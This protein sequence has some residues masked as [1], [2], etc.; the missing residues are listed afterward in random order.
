MRSRRS[1]VLDSITA[2]MA[3]MTINAVTISDQQNIGSRFRDIPGARNL[4]VVTTTSTA[5]HNPDNSVN[6]IICAHMS[7]RLPGVYAGPESGTYANHPT[8]GRVFRE[9]A[10]H[11]M[12][13][14]ATYTQ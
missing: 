5:T 2:G 13:P 14:P 6:V 10:T 11:S 12:T 8:S 9:N 3:K 4:N 1:I 7:A